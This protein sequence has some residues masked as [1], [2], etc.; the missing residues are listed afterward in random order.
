M[1]TTPLTLL[2]ALLAT[3]PHTARTHCVQRRSEEIAAQAAAS[4]ERYDVPVAL[5]LSIAWLESAMACDPRS[6]GSWG[7]PIARTRR[8]VAGNSDHTAS[9]LALGHRRC[10]ASWTEATNFFRTG[11]CHGAPPVGYTAETA[12]RIANRIALQAGAP[13]LD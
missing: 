8:G 4:A 13:A 3:L 12:M 2:F 7:A 5:L 6:G 9:A 1:H 10:P 11:R